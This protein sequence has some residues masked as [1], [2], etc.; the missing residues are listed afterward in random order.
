M[1]IF[2]IIIF[3]LLILF[4]SGLYI[5][6][7]KK[8]EKEIFK[9]Q[10]SLEQF[11]TLS[12]NLEEKIVLASESATS[13]EAK[14]VKA[15]ENLRSKILASKLYETIINQSHTFFFNLDLLA[16]F[17]FSNA[18]FAIQM[19]Y[20]QDEILQLNLKEFLSDR[21]L[22]LFLNFSKDPSQETVFFVFKFIDRFNEKI[23]I[24][25]QFT[26]QFDA[27]GKAT[28]IICVG[29]HH[30]KIST[31]HNIDFLGKS[32]E[33]AFSRFP[34]FIM[35]FNFDNQNIL[36]SKLKWANFNPGKLSDQESISFIDKS[37]LEISKSLSEIIS[38]RESKNTL[39]IFSPEKNTNQIYRIYPFVTDEVLFISFF[40][41]TIEYQTA[42]KIE[43]E[44]NFYKTILDELEIDVVVL[45]SKSQ[46]N[47]LENQHDNILIKLDFTK[48]LSITEG[49][50][51]F[52]AN[53]FQSYFNSLNECAKNFS[54][55]VNNSD[56]EGI[57]FL[58]HKIRATINT[59]Q[60]K[61]MELKFEEAINKI[62]KNLL[63]TEVDKAK[64]NSD[65]EKI[66]FEVEKQLR[67]F[68]RENEVKL[69]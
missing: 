55:H 59:F 19:G 45:D 12:S 43:Q 24:G 60:I 49:D 2:P 22:E 36:N 1:P 38:T 35:V 18:H 27:D 16:A 5:Y 3:L 39:N 10:N 29:N 34:C 48:V 46:Q 37:I 21:E 41:C 28:G 61:P 6:L 8:K 23:S 11:Q 65:M 13:K 42:T 40:E 30:L 47:E 57:K 9:L 68:A 63:F 69:K 53:L 15:E 31:D 67:S 17:T 7:L 25:A 33:E 26:K 20:A 62:N 66:C 64:I 32:A 4:I 54:I 14:F 44:R 50:M 56:L 52:M 58:L 51:N